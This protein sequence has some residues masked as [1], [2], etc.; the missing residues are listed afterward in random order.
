MPAE[1]CVIAR[2]LDVVVEGKTNKTT[3]LDIGRPAPI[4]VVTRSAPRLSTGTAKRFK[5]LTSQ[6]QLSTLKRL[7]HRGTDSWEI[8]MLCNDWDGNQRRESDQT[9]R[10]GVAADPKPMTTLN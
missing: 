1:G 9:I 4:T 7:Q 5:P 10:W 2:V 8:G 6:P 3:T